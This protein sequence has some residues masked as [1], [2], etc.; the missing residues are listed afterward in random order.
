MSEWVLFQQCVCYPE[1]E[2]FILGFE[3]E[4]VASVSTDSHVWKV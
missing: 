1:L 3:L 4:K 2:C